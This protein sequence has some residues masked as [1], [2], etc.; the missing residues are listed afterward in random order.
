MEREKEERRRGRLTGRCVRVCWGQGWG[1]GGGGAR[2]SEDGGW[3]LRVSREEKKLSKREDR[4][5]GQIKKIS[6]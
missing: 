2:G 4:N 5:T 6:A 3:G 1:E